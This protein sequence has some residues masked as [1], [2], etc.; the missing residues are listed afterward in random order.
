MKRAGPRAPRRVPASQLAWLAAALTLGGAIGGTAMGASA[1]GRDAALSAVGWRQRL[2]AAV[3]LQ[4]RF[5]DDGG[6]VVS[7][8]RY[9]SAHRPVALVLMYLSCSRLCPVTLSLTQQAFTRAGLVPGR[10][11]E[12][13]AVSIAPYDGVA[14][15][16]RRKA[17][18]APQGPWQRG[19]QLLTAAPAD[20]AK[21]HSAS[22]R[23]AAAAGFDFVRNAAV[24][25]ATGARA[26][27]Q[28]VHPAGW[29]L[30]DPRGHVSRYFFGLQYDPRVLR[31]AV[32]A[33]AAQAPPTWTQ[34]LRLLCD[35]LVALTGRY[36]A[37][38]LDALRALCVLLLGAGGLWL[39]RMRTPTAVDRRA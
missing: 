12:L 17:A 14:A 22:E 3:P 2:G 23:L 15:A 30:L 34:P 19:L 16:A 35:C 7:L 1:A 8:S 33:A 9:F 13:L 6:R 32:R 28:F 26:D 27:N 18:L 29:V 38:V 36:D 24:A 39:W 20:R 25:A 4:L 37:Q 11:F 21:A 5:S 31:Q 10:D